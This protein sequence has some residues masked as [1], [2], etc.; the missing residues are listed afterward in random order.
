MYT[1]SIEADRAWLV[2]AANP[3]GAAV[4]CGTSQTT[5]GSAT[6]DGDFRYYAG[7]RVGVAV[8]D[9]DLRQLPLTLKH[10]SPAERDQIEAWRGVTLLLR[11]VDGAVMF[12]SYLSIS[13]KRVLRTTPDDESD[14]VTYD[15]DVTFTRVSFD[16]AV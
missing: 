15:V 8:R 6:L 3:T 12:C 4:V 9:Q 1:I 5:A 10:L 16:E 11:T 2:E 13:D 7:G 14:N